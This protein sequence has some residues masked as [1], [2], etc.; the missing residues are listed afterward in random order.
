MVPATPPPAENPD[1]PSLPLTCVTCGLRVNFQCRSRLWFCCLKGMNVSLTRVLLLQ[2]LRETRVPAGS[3]VPSSEELSGLSI[4]SAQDGCFPGVQC[5]DSAFPR[6][7]AQVQS[8]VREL[9]ALKLCGLAKKKIFFK[10]RV[11][12][13][14]CF[15]KSVLA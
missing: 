1:R 5:Q 2:R 3:W 13:T 7:G 10:C 14:F 12:Y 8:L 11:M 6:Q 15:I 4:R 9:R